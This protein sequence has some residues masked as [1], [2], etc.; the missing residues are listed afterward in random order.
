MTIMKIRSSS[1]FSRT[2]FTICRASIAMPYRDCNMWMISR[3]SV[4]ILIR[5]GPSL[6]EPGRILS[7]HRKITWRTRIAEVCMKLELVYPA[8]S[9]CIRGT[10]RLLGI[11]LITSAC[12]DRWNRC[13]RLLNEFPF[14]LASCRVLV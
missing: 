12:T 11:Y 14:Q 4:K 1:C 13:W 2:G 10:L 5:T 6:G 9:I 8:S 3:N 7:T